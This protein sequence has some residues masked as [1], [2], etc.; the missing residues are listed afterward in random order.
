MRPARPKHLQPKQTKAEAVK[1]LRGLEIGDCVRFIDENGN[2]T[3]GKVQ[4]I[5]VCGMA[6][7]MVAGWRYIKWFYPHEVELL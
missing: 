6:L 4:N 5:D 7:I 2:L 1:A 3:T